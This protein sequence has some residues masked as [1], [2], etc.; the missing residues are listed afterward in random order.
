MSLKPCALLGG[1]G[2][3]LSREFFLNG[4]I[5]CVLAYI[6][7]RFCLYKILKTT[8]FYIK[9]KKKFLIFEIKKKILDTRLLWGNNYSREEYF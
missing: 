5:W 6:L 4:A 2:G 8:T 3:M 9:I 1:F 7:I